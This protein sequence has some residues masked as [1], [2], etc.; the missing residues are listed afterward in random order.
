MANKR[1]H[2]IITGDVQGVFFRSNTEKRA[3][4]LGLTGWVRNNPGGNVEIVAEGE[5]SVLK[6][7]LAWCNEGPEMSRVEKINVKWEDSTGEF[8]YF[9]V[10][11]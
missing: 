7:F 4:S 5:E 6:Q 3:S 8:K 2:A 9:S 11:Y 1:L 10:K